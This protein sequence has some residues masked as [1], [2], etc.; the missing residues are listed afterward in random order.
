MLKLGERIK[1]WN[2]RY[3]V[4]INKP[5]GLLY[6]EKNPFEEVP[7]ESFK[8]A[9]YQSESHTRRHVRMKEEPIFFIDFNLVSWSWIGTTKYYCRFI[10]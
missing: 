10:I 6:Y 1:T 3:F 5:R 2:E 8:S 4:L 7:A 9:N